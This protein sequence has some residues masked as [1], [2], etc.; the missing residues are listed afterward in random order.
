MADGKEPAPAPEKKNNKLIMM[1]GGGIAVVLV[2]VGVM[3]M[4]GG[5]SEEVQAV[6]ENFVEYAMPEGMYQLKDGAYLSLGYSIVVSDK[7]LKDV[8]NEVGSTSAG[9]LQDGINMILGNKTRE[10]LI[11][12]AHK[13]EAFAQELKKVVEE[14]VFQNY[15]KSKKSPQ[16]MIEVRRVFI[17]KFV[18]QSG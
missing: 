6:A 9:S 7:K 8:E 18:T 14:R 3:M 12:G 5:K 4:M 17:S 16:D 1:I 10:D 15:N 11:N 2:A 13:R